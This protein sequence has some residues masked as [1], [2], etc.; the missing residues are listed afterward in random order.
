MK[1]VHQITRDG[2]SD[3]IYYHDDGEIG[4]VRIEGTES[5]VGKDISTK[6]DLV[7][8]KHTYLP[9]P[10]FNTR[11][12]V[13]RKN[14]PVIYTIQRVDEGSIQVADRILSIPS[15]WDVSVLVG[16]KVY[17][18]GGSMWSADTGTL[19]L[20][21]VWTAAMA[22]LVKD[23]MSIKASQYKQSQLQYTRYLDF[24]NDRSHG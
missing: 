9:I 11:A 21:D 23:W 15:C 6:P 14:K 13:W 1:I 7:I 5:L 3:L 20:G 16:Y 8:D 17:I 4:T 19:L 10:A 22:R 18:A 2:H 12:T 24:L